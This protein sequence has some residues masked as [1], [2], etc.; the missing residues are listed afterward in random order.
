MKLK[1][2]TA[3]QQLDVPVEHGISRIVIPSGFSGVWIIVIEDASFSVGAD[4]T[5][6]DM[7]NQEI[8]NAVKEAELDE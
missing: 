3:Y 7:T 2:I 1:K 5:S 4:Y 8:T 6:D